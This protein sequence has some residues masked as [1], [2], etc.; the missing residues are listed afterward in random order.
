MIQALKRFYSNFGDRGVMFIMFAFSVVVHSLLSLDME[1]PAVNPDEIGVASVAAFYS[2][3]DWSALMSQVCYYYGYIQALF[4]APLFMLFSDPY[5]LY[6]ACLVMNG[7]LISFIPLIAYHIA[8]KL[9]IT[10]VWQKVVIAFC[11]GSYITYIAHSK[12]MWN[13]AVCSLLPWVLMWVMFMAMDSRK[14]GARIAWSAGAG[15][16]CAV[17]YA[18]HTRMLATAAA[19]VVTLLAVRICMRRRILVLP[20]FF[21]ALAASFV[22]E[23]FIR[24]ALIEAVWKGNALG[25]TLEYEADKV[26]AI[27][28]PEGFGRFVNVLFGNLYTFTTSTVGL[29]A[30][31]CVIFFVLIIA[32]ISEW[33]R[34]RNGTLIDGVKV[35]EPASKHTYSARVTTLGIYAFLSAGAAVMV[36]VLFKFN[37]DQYGTIKDLTMFG[38]YTDNVAPI[39]ILLVLIFLFRY[40]VTLRQTA[41]AA[42][43]YGCV[44][45][46][47]FTLSFETV[48][49]A[50]G[51][52]ESP[53]LGLQPWRIGE[54]ITQSFTADSFIIMTSVT[55][56][57]LA[58][59][60]VFAACTKK[61]RRALI[62]G[63]CCCLFTYTTVFTSTVY[64]PQRAQD[65]LE[66][67]EPARMA[68]TLL[69]NE[70][71][72]PLIVAYNIGSRNAGLIQ[73]LNLN[74]RVTIAR[75]PGAIPENCILI[76]DEE[77]ALP[78]A[79]ES[80]DYIGTEGGLT[81]YACGE[82][83]RDYIRYK[84]SAD[85]VE[86]FGNENSEA[87]APDIP[88]I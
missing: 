69:Y 47:F 35:Y 8:G 75:S 52:R 21:P 12:F 31:G 59:V 61:S 20:V 5:S 77:D 80:C 62:S 87:A 36:S 57:F 71:A 16:L 34:D 73:F 10:K 68:S 41:V 66:R 37:S 40:G 84:R 1:L 49:S 46:G 50:G 3:R 60:A 27:F 79:P 18:A 86:Y 74:T 2:G 22:G 51:Y 6:K 70:A 30:F 38:R 32:R 33:H 28:T 4:Y 48:N 54:D 7:V 53:V 44:C 78:I 67:T 72:S 45:A 82:T 63:A 19:F 55:F 39:M 23:Y 25:N 24:Q 15:V 9:G 43:V 58:L 88:E 17:C 56:S 65:N 13:E 64:L 42:I 29:G 14:T 11:C 81:A 26:L 83:A 76:M 85:T